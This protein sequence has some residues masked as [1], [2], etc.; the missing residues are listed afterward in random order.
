MEVINYIQ[1][2]ELYSSGV[3][4]TDFSDCVY[5]PEFIDEF[6]IENLATLSD[7]H[8]AYYC[9]LLLSMN[10]DIGILLIIDKVDGHEKL[11]DTCIKLNCDIVFDDYVELDILGYQEDRNMKTNLFAKRRSK[12]L[13]RKAFKSLRINTDVSDEEKHDDGFAET[14]GIK[15]KILQLLDGITERLRR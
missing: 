3:I 4:A 2:P 6:I 13:D 7:Q 14:T 5:A 11:I 1:N 9:S 10:Q 8:T 12:K 15:Q